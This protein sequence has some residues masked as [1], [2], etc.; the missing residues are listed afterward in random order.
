[1]LSSLVVIFSWDDIQPPIISKPYATLEK[2]KD[3]RQLA[4]QMNQKSC[5]IISGYDVPHPGLY[6]RIDEC[7]KRQMPFATPFCCLL[8]Y[9]VYSDKSTMKLRNALSLYLR[10]NSEGEWGM[11]KNDI[12]H[13]GCQ[14]YMKVGVPE[15]AINSL[16]KFAYVL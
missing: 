1:M 7:G 6:S 14:H 12:S 15:K 13:S 9:Q 4:H 5:V 3:A 10:D 11:L 2:E 8:L 16:D